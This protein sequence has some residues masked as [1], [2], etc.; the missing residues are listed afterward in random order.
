MVTII[1]VSPLDA[2]EFYYN[3]EGD[4]YVEKRGDKSNNYSPPPVYVE[5]PEYK[6]QKINAN[7]IKDNIPKRK[8]SLW[9]KNIIGERVF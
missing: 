7:Q 2:G 9:Y 3:D 1:D 8:T 4:D 5:I 6:F